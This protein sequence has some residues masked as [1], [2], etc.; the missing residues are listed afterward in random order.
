M[1]VSMHDVDSREWRLAVLR[2]DMGRNEKLA[3]LAA[4]TYIQDQWGGQ[5]GHWPEEEPYR[6]ECAALAGLSPSVFAR[7]YRGLRAD[8]WL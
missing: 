7:Y 6:S 1:A 5:V 2:S 3:A 8:G 4:E